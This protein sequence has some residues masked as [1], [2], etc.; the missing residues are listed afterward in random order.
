MGSLIS[1]AQFETLRDLT[2][3]NVTFDE[4]PKHLPGKI[5]EDEIDQGVLYQIGEAFSKPATSPADYTRTQMVA[6]LFRT[7][8]FNGVGYNSSFGYGYNVA[9]FDIT[10]AKWRNCFLFENNIT[11]EFQERA[12]PIYSSHQNHD[13][14]PYS[15]RSVREN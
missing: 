11:L 3:V 5:S 7:Q 9:L 2:V 14:Y 15:A 1:V 10:D 6:E 4:R 13:I 8:G 12:A